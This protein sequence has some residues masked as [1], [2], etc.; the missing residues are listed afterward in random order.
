LAQ[1]ILAQAHRPGGGR[2][3]RAGPDAMKAMAVAGKAALAALLLL[4]GVP[5]AAPSGGG[6]AAEEAGRVAGEIAD[7][8][9]AG[10]TS[11]VKLAPGET[12]CIRSAASEL[13]SDIVEVMSEVVSLIEQL[14]GVGHSSSDDDKGLAR[15]LV[16][17]LLEVNQVQKVLL[18][19]CL[20]HDA[21]EAIDATTEHL[22]NAEYMKG[23]LVANKVDIAKELSLAAADFALKEYMMGAEQ[24]GLAMR[25]VLLE[26]ESAP[27]VVLPEGELTRE[28]IEEIALGLLE[29]FFGGNGSTIAIGVAPQQVVINLPECLHDNRVFLSTVAH[30]A[31][32]F[33]A[34]LEVMSKHRA[35][36]V[37]DIPSD[38]KLQQMAVAVVVHMP[39]VMQNCGISKE[40]RIMFMDA[41]K[42]IGAGN[43]K[44]QLTSENLRLTKTVVMGYQA[45]AMKHWEELGQEIG[46]VLRSLLV[47]QFA[48]KYSVDG[49]GKLRIAPAGVTSRDSA[50]SGMLAVTAA[51]FLFVFAMLVLRVASAA[52]KRKV[53]GA[54]SES[55]HNGAASL[56]SIQGLGP[57]P[58]EVLID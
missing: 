50:H 43:V 44:L 57:L 22:K 13:S 26:A 2:R 24:I 17:H 55:C 38:D 28:S 32:G 4:S 6:G 9:I 58:V 11:H 53:A 41:V 31:L 10:F 16:A 56:D 14:L 7:G 45:F 42:A 19:Q 49:D 30:A 20:Q 36:E 27:D 51:M 25:R 12:E 21:R 52:G 33:F 46:S 39:G 40:N 47:G 35:G 37:V 3:G 34:K 8:W 29:G 54:V 48:D 5:A 15:K 1:A 23:K 18:G